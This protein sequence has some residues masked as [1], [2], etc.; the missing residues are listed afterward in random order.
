MKL[1]NFK[2]TKYKNTFLPLVEAIFF[3]SLV[4]YLIFFLL[5]N[6][7]RGFI[8]NYF[9]INIFLWLS[10]FGGI[11][12]LWFKPNSENI[13]GTKTSFK[14][15][16]FMFLG[17]VYGLTIIWLRVKEV[18]FTSYAVGLITIIIIVI[19][20]IIVFKKENQVV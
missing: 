12:F 16:L 10:I 18:H 17:V 2:I 9:N 1:N 3:T 8:S 19:L 6:I 13:V 20:L 4:S 7:K 11:L 14:N 15:Y 5:D